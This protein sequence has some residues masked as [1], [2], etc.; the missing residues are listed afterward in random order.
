MLNYQLIIFK[1]S[2]IIFI[3]NFQGSLQF[4]LFEI[5]ERQN[6]KIFL[7]NQNQIIIKHSQILSFNVLD[8]SV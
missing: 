1:I 8:F 4:I 6:M 5:K 2:R 3:L 7:P